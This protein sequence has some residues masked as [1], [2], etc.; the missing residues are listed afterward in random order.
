MGGGLERKE[1]IMNSNT[2]TF[3]EL[4]Y[5][6]PDFDK[7]QNRINELADCVKHATAYSTV[8]QA[9]YEY[10][11]A[12]TESKNMVYM[13]YCRTYHDAS[14][15]AMQA[16]FAEVMQAAA[17]IDESAWEDALLTSPFADEI[18]SE[19]GS[20]FRRIIYRNNCVRKKGKELQ[21]KD[22]NCNAVYQQLVATM[23]FNLRGKEVTQSEISVDLGNP[24]R[25]LRYDALISEFTGFADKSDEFSEILSK[26]TGL[27]NQIAKENG[28]DSYLDYAN[29]THGRQDYGE[30]ELTTFCSEVENYIVPLYRKL[31]EKQAER[32]GLDQIQ[33]WDANILFPEGNPKPKGDLNSLFAAANK[34]YHELS[35]EAGAFY[36]FMLKHQLMDVEGSPK[37]ISRMGFCTFF[38]SP[39]KAPY[40]FA[41]C[42][43]TLR[44][45]MVFTHE[46][47]HALQGYLSTRN[48]PLDKLVDGT[49]DIAEIPSKTMELLT[50]DYAEDYFGD[51]A[52]RFVFSH[53]HGVVR[54]ICAYCEVHSLESWHYTHPD[55]TIEE[56]SMMDLSLREKYGLFP[57]ISTL[58]DEL[59][60]L[61]K[62]GALIFSSLPLYM[63]PR[64]VISY[65][66]SEMGA[67]QIWQAYCENKEEGW[68]AYH[69]LLSAGGSKS[70]QELLQAAGL[71][72]PYNREVVERTAIQLENTIRCQVQKL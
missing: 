61:I 38:G 41:N 22:E 34:M 50:Y 56:L 35:A 49:T 28:F 5:V 16:E 70:Y 43:G 44:D 58:P 48:L 64:Y 7:L 68:A 9:I 18:N 10:D 14:N 42:D 11:I 15:E 8:R 71:G 17:M 65:A 33:P 12:S 69:R 59:L 51:D 54:E 53:L 52:N 55:A 37:K 27:R 63:F 29:L 62:R 46:L 26:V 39:L 47:G 21:A 40:I 4:E 1:T 23:R 3:P 20:E 6:R 2:W 57:N 25:A 30:K 67:L 72:F 36:D 60:Q 13:H 66:L 31:R 45:V 24:D 32:L 19:F